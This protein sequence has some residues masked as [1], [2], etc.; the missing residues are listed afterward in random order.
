MIVNI[1]KQKTTKK[2]LSL[3]NVLQE[4]LQFVSADGVIP[5]PYLQPNESPA[6]RSFS[7][8]CVLPSNTSALPHP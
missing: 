4:H 5:Q 7:P 2:M 8:Q 1:P 6:D 3:H